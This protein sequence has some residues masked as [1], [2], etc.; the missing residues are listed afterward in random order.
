MRKVKI[1][2]TLGP[3]SETGPVIRDLLSAGVNAVR[4]NFSHGDHA[5]HEAVYRAVRETADE[6]G[7]PCAVV[8]DLQG[9]KIR[10]G[11]LD[12]PAVLDR[13]DRVAIG[14]EQPDTE[15]ETVFLPCTYA[16]IAG[17]VHRGERILIDDGRIELAAERIEENSIICRVIEG[18]I[19][20]EHKGINLPGVDV[21]VSSI[22]EKD[23]K[24][25]EFS[26]KLGVDYIAVS[27]VRTGAG[28]RRVKELIK[29]RG[30]D[31]PV[32]AKIEKPEALDNIDAIIEESFGIMVARG[33]LAVETSPEEVPIVQKMLI[34]QTNSRC[35][36]DI[37]ATQMLES[38]I[39]HPTPTRAES[40]DVANAVLDG[41]DVVMLS[42]ETAVGS[43]PV[44]TVRMMDRIIR[45]AGQSLYFEKHRYTPDDDDDSVLNGITHAAALAADET[46]AAALAVY[47][48]WGDGVFM[49]SKKRPETDIIAFTPDERLYNR[50][51]LY[52]GVHPFLCKK[53]EGWEEIAAYIKKELV[54]RH[55]LAEGNTIV[56]LVNDEH[57]NHVLRITGV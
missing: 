56:C 30:A 47:S 54:D 43:Y 53:I 48:L 25:L 50:F 39:Q 52:Y 31:V 35:R 7:V 11:K 29:D 17:D 4:L 37:V 42:G 3:A 16:G 44:R 1:L 2:A 14:A 40:A 38:M 32:I 57:N 26:L 6:L 12:S 49:I 18:G 41:A 34:K 51:S 24:D 36:L 22:T 33:D 13:G 21:S 8:A 20:S 10:V 5:G 23:V 15:T 45:F 55:I 27:F 19:V 28:L 46:R 9:P